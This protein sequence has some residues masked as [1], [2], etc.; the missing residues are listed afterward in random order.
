MPSSWILVVDDDPGM[1]ALVSARLEAKKFSVTTADDAMQAFI[2]ARDIQPF[3]I[4]S[5][6]HMPGFGYGSDMLKEI[7]KVPVL[8]NTP[9]IF[10]T[11]SEPEKARQLIP[12]DPLVR[13]LYKPPNWTLMTQAIRDLTGINIPEL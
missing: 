4:I 1:A 11:G 10:L 5:D 6:L 8:K 2:Q 13:I 7:R 3:L 9:V 12:N